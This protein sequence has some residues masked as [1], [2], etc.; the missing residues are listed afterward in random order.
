[1]INLENLS[2]KTALEIFNEAKQKIEIM[3]PNW[4]YKSESDPGIT[5]IELF[6]WLKFNQHNR[7][8]NISTRLKINLLKLLGIKLK[9]RCGSRALIH[10]NNSKSDINVPK[11][12]K[13]VADSLIFENENPQFIS[14]SD[15]LSVRF[16]NPEFEEKKNYYD[17]NGVEKIYTFGT[18]NLKNGENR[19]FIINLSNE[20]PKNKE[21][22]LYFKIYSD[23]KRNEVGQNFFEPF[24]SVKWQCW[25]I[26]DGKEDWYDMEFK[27]YTHQF[28]FSGNVVLKNKVQM[29]PIGGIYLVKCKLISSDYDFM[30][31][32]SNIKINV[33]EV[34]QIDTKCES[35]FVKKSDIE[36]KD[37]ILNFS[38]NTHLGLYGNHVVYYKNG[39]SWINIEKFQFFPDIK[40][41]FCSFEIE[42]FD[43]SQ[44]ENDDEIFM[45]VSYSKDIKNKM[46]VGSGTGFSGLTFDIDFEDFSKYENF[47]IMVG[48]KYKK[49][50]NFKIW[51]RVDDFFGSKKFDNHFVYE[52]N[53]KVLAFGDNHHGAIPQVGKD[54]IKLCSLVFTKGE[55]SNLK[56]NMINDVETKN[57]TLKNSNIVQIS[58]ATGGTDD[59][60][61]E[62]AERR[63]S[64]IFKDEKRAVILEDYSKIIKKT[65][66]IILKDVSI[67]SSNDRMRNKI[68]I[69]VRIPD[70]NFVPESYKKNIINWF[71]NFRLINTEVE[72]LSPVIIKLDIKIRVI[73][74][75]GYNVDSSVIRK[76]LEE[77][78][79]NL[80]EKMGQK[81]V[82]GDILKR[83]ENLE[84]VHYLENLDINPNGYG[85]DSN[86]D[87]DNIDVPINALYELGKV[88]LVSLI[89][90]DF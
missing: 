90:T 62:D 74:K 80:N 76:E 1:M 6:S 32:I 43:V 52:E 84:F 34:T 45:I 67:S 28:L 12:T 38:L 89:N 83:I 21:I 22:S 53:L 71:E 33:F 25:G 17:L 66:G 70:L 31:Q 16:V 88:D 50:I 55:N 10:I 11:N 42:N 73:L 85:F 69:A 48:E 2:D 82:Y 20:F 30:P 64:E 44:F 3:N 78:V 13:W 77:F 86:S 19:E 26:L 23:Y 27:D 4:T 37:N 36:T 75:S 72:I 40:N 54:N 47:R 81:L 14:K 65:P 79:D 18:K 15:I 68:F 29:L 24:A 63:V 8:N 56:E 51:D 87:C 7:L 57:K 39:D 61:F 60:K 35:V 46:I 5:L 49:N 9:K 58:P 59:E 41:G